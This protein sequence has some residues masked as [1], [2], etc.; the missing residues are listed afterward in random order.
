MSNA[1]R[2]GADTTHA[3]QQ[4]F[5]QPFVVKHVNLHAVT[6]RRLDM[7]GWPGRF[8]IFLEECTLKIEV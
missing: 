3:Y 8:P 7:M 6:N 5:L 1:G 4:N 2:A